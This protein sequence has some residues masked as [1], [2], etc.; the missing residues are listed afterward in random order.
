[1]NKKSKKATLRAKRRDR[2]EQI[3]PHAV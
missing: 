3:L 1:M 2:W